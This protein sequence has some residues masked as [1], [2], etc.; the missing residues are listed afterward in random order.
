MSHLAASVGWVLA[1]AI[2]LRRTTCLPLVCLPSRPRPRARRSVRLGTICNPEAES[3]RRPTARSAMDGH[4]RQPSMMASSDSS[5]T[6]DVT[7]RNGSSR[8][9]SSV[10][11]KMLSLCRVEDLLGAQ[12]TSFLAV[13]KQHASRMRQSLEG[14]I[15]APGTTSVPASPSTYL[16]VRTSSATASSAYPKRRTCS[17][18]GRAEMI[19]PG[20]TGTRGTTTSRTALSEESATESEGCKAALKP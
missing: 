12:I 1:V 13:D 8:T 20:A 7:V 17:A 14:A 16:D 18:P 5:A 10:L 19:C 15:S 4:A 11:Q 6:A 9:T 2:L 3:T